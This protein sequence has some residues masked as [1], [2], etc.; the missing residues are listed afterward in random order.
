MACN[1]S[2]NAI[3]LNWSD[4]RGRIWAGAVQRRLQGTGWR[5]EGPLEAVGERGSACLSS[6]V[7]S[8]GKLRVPRLLP[9]RYTGREFDRGILVLLQGLREVVFSHLLARHLLALARPIP[10]CYLLSS[11][12]APGSA[13]GKG[14]S[15][16]NPL[17]SSSLVCPLQTTGL[18]PVSHS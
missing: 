8:L 12:V 13:V 16:G 1:L 3:V 2:R 18:D 14:P 5:R 15:G 7:G 9:H 6:G 4:L 11:A 17:C 10:L